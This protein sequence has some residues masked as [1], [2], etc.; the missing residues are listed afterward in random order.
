MVSGVCSSCFVGPVR[1]TYSACPPSVACV[2]PPHRTALIGPETLAINIVQVAHG[3]EQDSDLGEHV[4]ID[5][6]IK[7]PILLFE[8]PMNSLD[9][10]PYLRYESGFVC[11]S[12]CQLLTIAPADGHA[13]EVTFA[14]KVVLHVPESPIHE[15]IITSFN[16]VVETGCE[17]NLQDRSIVQGCN[18]RE[19]H[20]HYV[21]CRRANRERL[22]QMGIFL[23]RVR[24]P[25]AGVVGA[26]TVPEVSSIVDES[27][28]VGSEEFL[29]ER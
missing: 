10:P 18:G 9:D 28:C 5:S 11:F 29:D 17:S 26:F 7:E 24:L 25:L 21:S 14:F 20:I 1:P 3:P 12:R 8:D 13:D 19:Y 23:D 6:V 16:Q 2:R 27:Q 15:A 4:I 22:A